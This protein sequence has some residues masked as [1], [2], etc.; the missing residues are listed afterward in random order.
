M[1]ARRAGTGKAR[2]GDRHRGLIGICPATGQDRLRGVAH[3]V[4]PRRQRQQAEAGGAGE[5]AVPAAP[6]HRSAGGAPQRIAL[7]GTREIAVTPH[8][9]PQRPG[10]VVQFPRVI[11][12]ETAG[13]D[14]RR[15]HHHGADA[16]EAAEAGERQ[17]QAVILA[18]HRLVG[19]ADTQIIG[20]GQ[21]HLAGIEGAAADRRP[22]RR[23]DRQGA[24]LRRR[25]GK[26][27]RP[28]GII[29]AALAIGEHRAG[30]AERRQQPARRVR[31]NY[32]RRHSNLSPR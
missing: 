27:D 13:R 19:A 12:R 20:A 16:H 25:G 2:I 1:P 28:R 32:R 7:V 11:V 15:Q 31:H 9:I 10:D 3:Q 8:E 4:E 17:G 18:A 24:W 22:H 30:T 26:R 21:Q 5:I 6:Q 29:S 14:R 23:V